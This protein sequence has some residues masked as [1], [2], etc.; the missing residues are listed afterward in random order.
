MSLEIEKK[1]LVGIPPEDVLKAAEKKSILQSYLI[2]ENGFDTARVR[3]SRDSHGREKYVF[4]AKKSLGGLQREEVEREIGR[5]EYTELR[6]AAV[7][8]IVKDR[9]AL[10]YRGHI[11]EF[12]V[13][14][15]WTVK[16]VLE[17]DLSAENEAYELP[18][19]VETIGDVSEESEYTNAAL[20]ERFGKI[21]RGGQTA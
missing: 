13:Y 15:C 6:S 7:S 21:N 9:Y 4:T 10:P 5:D 14:P 16:C 19:Y 12:D 18:G 8:E 17:I 11:L 2:P 3:L 20:A 1:F